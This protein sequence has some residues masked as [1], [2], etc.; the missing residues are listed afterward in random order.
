MRHSASTAVLACI[1]AGSSGCSILF[2][3][4]PPEEVRPGVP[5]ECTSS[6]VAPGLDTAVVGET[7]VTGSWLA[8]MM[9]TCT[10]QYGGGS[11][12]TRRDRATVLA[13]TAGIAAVYGLSAISGY[14][15][16]SRCSHMKTLSQCLVGNERAC[17]KL[18]PGERPPGS[19]PPPRWQPRDRAPAPA[20]APP[21]SAP[22]ASAPPTWAPPAA[23]PE[24]APPPASAPAGEPAPQYPPQ[25]LPQR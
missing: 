8:L 15:S 20:W 16:A 12:T 6:R 14:S 21:P 11:C 10:D 23:P 2:M 1:L 3:R 9:S 4:R 24:Y 13:V 19:A 5:V 25:E 18:P 7:V 17:W 22:P